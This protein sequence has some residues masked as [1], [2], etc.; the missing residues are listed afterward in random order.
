MQRKWKLV[1]KKRKEEKETE[2]TNVHPDK[3]AESLGNARGVE[4]QNKINSKIN[5][6]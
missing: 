2:K 6:A 1:C 5:Y 3:S 4:L